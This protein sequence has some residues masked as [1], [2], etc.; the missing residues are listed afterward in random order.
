MDA[1]LSSTVSSNTDFKQSTNATIPYQQQQQHNYMIPGGYING[2]QIPMYI[3]PNTT[4]TQLSQPPSFLQPPNVPHYGFNNEM[5][6]QIA[7]NNK[8]YPTATTTMQASST[9]NTLLKNQQPQAPT[10]TTTTVKES[11][12]NK[13]SKSKPGKKKTVH[14]IKKRINSDIGSDSSDSRMVTSFY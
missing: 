9:L 1:T 12:N 8:N 11:N 7:Y 2:Q 5:Y 4:T 14:K 6:S 10:T 13:N 3:Q